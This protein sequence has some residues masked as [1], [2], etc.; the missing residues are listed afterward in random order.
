MESYWPGAGSKPD[1]S[2]HDIEHSRWYAGV[3]KIVLSRSLKGASLENTTVISD[4]LSTRI[5][6]IRNTEGEDILVF[7]SPG[8]T[9]ALMKEN[10]IDGYWLFLNPVVLGEGIALFNGDQQKAELELLGSHPFDC[11][12]IE[13]N[14]TTKT[15]SS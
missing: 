5:N 3:H 8:A 6:T 11:G 1:A 15:H 4:Q 12:V 9:H 14:Y 7:G 2:R 13:L 10:L